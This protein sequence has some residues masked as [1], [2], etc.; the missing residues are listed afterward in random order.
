M[1]IKEL[2]NREIEVLEDGSI[3]LVP[4]KKVPK[5]K[6]FVPGERSDYYYLSPYGNIRRETNDDDVD[7]WLFQHHLVFETEEQAKDY[8][9]FL[10][11]LDK[12]QW[13]PT[14][15]GWRD[16]GFSKYYM[17]LFYGKLRTSCVHGAQFIT[18]W[19]SSEDDIIAFIKEVGEDRIKAYMFDVW[20]A[21]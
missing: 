18:V 4:E 17:Y 21:E 2:L 12:Y 11:I 8:K 5:L 20:E 14:K 3:K 16:D 13:K 6:K 9:W 10:N 7:K 19:F 1:K 15:E